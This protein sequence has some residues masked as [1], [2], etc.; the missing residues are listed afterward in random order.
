MSIS[1]RTDGAARAIC[2]V[3]QI[4][5]SDEQMRSVREIIDQAMVNVMRE[6][7]ESA[8]RAVMECCS[9]D[10]DIAHKVAAEIKRRQG[11]LVANLSSMR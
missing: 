4:E 9:A 8:T 5:P 10:L 3:L 11:A 6:A 1:E 7:G 2:A